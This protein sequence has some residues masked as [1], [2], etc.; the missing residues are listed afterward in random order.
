LQSRWGLQVFAS[1]DQSID[2]SAT[3]AATLMISAQPLIAFLLSGGRSCR[4]SYARDP[5]MSAR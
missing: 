3:C 4:A 2:W 1:T 5:L